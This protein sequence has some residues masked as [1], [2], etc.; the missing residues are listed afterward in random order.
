MSQHTGPRTSRIDCA[1][2]VYSKDVRDAIRS[3]CDRIDEIEAAFQAGKLSG[4]G[5]KRSMAAPWRE[6]VAV[7][8]EEPNAAADKTMDCGSIA[9][10]R[11]MRKLQDAISTM[12]RLSAEAR[13]GAAYPVY[14]RADE[15][16]ALKATECRSVD[17]DR[18]GHLGRELHGVTGELPDDIR[19]ARQHIRAI[20][21]E[22]CGL[23][24]RATEGKSKDRGDEL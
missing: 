14:L 5:R 3:A 11:A 4:K 2:I 7:A 24:A 17:P 12:D 18:V 22:L 23:A 20:A 9:M 21:A 1:N 10:A 16:E 6:L 13:D 8:D 15:I 19:G